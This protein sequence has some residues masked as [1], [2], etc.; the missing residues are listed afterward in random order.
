MDFK[1]SVRL[2]LEISKKISNETFESQK[3]TNKQ[4]NLIGGYIDELSNCFKQFYGS[5]EEFVKKAYVKKIELAYKKL[6]Q[7]VDEF[8]VNNDQ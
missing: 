3:M 8:I 4:Y 1:D 6:K 2:L 7:K 5:N